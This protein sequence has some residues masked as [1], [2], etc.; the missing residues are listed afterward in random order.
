MYVL[1]PIFL[2]VATVT[3]P[4]VADSIEEANTKLADYGLPPILF[5]PPGFT[6]RTYPM[7]DNLFCFHNGYFT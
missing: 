6:N 7:Q 2:S 3:A 4:A 5:T 1:A